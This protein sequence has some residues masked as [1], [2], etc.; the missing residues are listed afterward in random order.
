MRLFSKKYDHHLAKKRV[1]VNR[2]DKG[3]A[4]A[5]HPVPRVAPRDS[6]SNKYK[7]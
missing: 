4:F 5:K 1:L 2:S 3:T 7:S 6:A